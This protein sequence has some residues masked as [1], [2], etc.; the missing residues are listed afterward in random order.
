MAIRRVNLREQVKQE[1]LDRLGSGKLVPGRS[2][3]EVAL[4]AELGVSRTPLREA[5]IALE[6]EGMIVSVPGRGFSGVPISGAEF[7]S[8]LPIIVALE[9]LALEL[10]DIDELAAIAPRLQ[11]EAEAFS[12]DRA[13]HADLIRADDRWHS[14]MLS[15]CPNARLLEIIATQKAALHRY[16]RLI[17]PDDA[18][19]R[20]T[21]GE[22][23]SIARCLAARDKPAAIA[24]LQTNW[25]NGERELLA[26]LDKQLDAG[27]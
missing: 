16:E 23:L 3:N 4:A 19:V 1:I 24:A 11:A 15:V 2:I 12:S 7:R 27:D 14:M 18:L 5:L 9:S 25:R 26:Q 8:I 13:V 6:R 21:A 10:S 17:V 22:H 20:R